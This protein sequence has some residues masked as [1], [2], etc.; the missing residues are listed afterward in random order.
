[1]AT[2]NGTS[3]RDLVHR[4]GDGHTPGF[5][6]TEFNTA[7]VGADTINTGAGIDEIYSDAG[8]DIINAGDDDDFVFSGSGNDTVDGG[9]GNDTIIGGAGIDLL[10]GGTGTDAFQFNATS[11]ITNLAESINGGADEDIIDFAQFNAFGTVNL[12]AATITD[13][14][15][16]RFAGGGNVV[17]LTAA[18][19]GA[20]TKIS[21]GFATDRFYLSAAGTVDLTGAI[22]NDLVDEF[23]GTSGNDTFILT[24]VGV[25]QTVNGLAG[26]DKIYGSLGNDNFDGGAGVDTVNGY[27][28][29]DTLKGGADND[30]INAGDGN[31]VVN[32]GAGTD[33]LGG[34]TGNDIFVVTNVAEISGLAETVSAGDDTDLLRFD[35]AGKVDL[36]Q[37]T[38]ISLEQLGLNGNDVTITAAQL[39]QFDQINASFATDRIILAAAGT[40]D[41]STAIISNLLDELRGSSGNDVI[42][43]Q[44]NAQGL[45][46][47]ARE[48]NDTINAGEGNDSLRGWTGNDFLGGGDG[49]DMLDGGAGTDNFSGGS[50]N[51]IIE[52]KQSS[53]I[54]GLAETI[55]G[56]ADVDELNF[57][58][59]GAIGTIDLS[60]ATITAVEKLSIGNNA[61]IMTG[62]QMS[63]FE[64]IAAGFGT[65]RLIMSAAG[66]AD[67][68]GD[69]IVLVDE[70]RGSSG[71][72]IVKLSGVVDGQTVNGMAGNDNIGGSVGNDVI[73]GG[74]GADTLSGSAGNDTLIGG[75][76]ADR[77]G[78]GSGVD[79]FLY[80]LATEAPVA[81]AH[82]VITDFTHGTDLID[83]R[84]LDAKDDVAGD[85]AFTF[86]GGGAFTG[87]GGQLRYSN[88]IIYGEMTGDT[89]A[90]FQIE[91]ANK[92]AIT[93]VDFLL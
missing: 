37:A 63:G 83:L 14:E 38:L 28:G 67:F 79:T 15:H 55:N 16:F 58:L 17:T 77:M 51:D 73:D 86:I 53:D 39:S 5:G 35:G 84:Q 23:R 2:I 1:M 40:I 66:T 34:G 57:T 85:Q 29:N 44:A 70:I 42:K 36:T 75:S 8:D 26:N 32:G 6:V 52:V 10:I 56:G 80:R 46:V 48:G 11:D 76:S 30:T 50:G 22:I 91:L 62:A 12:T 81:T 41:L 13:V 93:A 4:N 3:G 72:D 89:T 24:D 65:E 47:D 54:S 78:G 33:K 19:L 74:S 7:T 21:A 25:G 71:N 88:G 31:D 27:E 90:D 68:T 69:T 64:T 20:F 45:F 49:N 18:Q 9:T 82:D 60:L 43:F 92:A 87:V 59:L 61:M